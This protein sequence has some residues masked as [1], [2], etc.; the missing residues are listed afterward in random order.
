MQTNPSFVIA[1]KKCTIKKKSRA[2]EAGSAAGAGRHGAGQRQVWDAMEPVAGRTT[3]RWR[4]SRLNWIHLLHALAFAVQGARG[5]K[6]L[7]W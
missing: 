3:A 2:G 6:G 1:A 4:G 5:W 7:G